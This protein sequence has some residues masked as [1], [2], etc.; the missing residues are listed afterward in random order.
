MS[1]LYYILFF[2]KVSIKMVGNRKDLIFRFFSI[3]ISLYIIIYKHDK[4]TT[5]QNRI[6]PIG[7]S[8]SKTNRQSQSHHTHIIYIY[9]FIYTQCVSCPAFLLS[10]VIYIISICHTYIHLIMFHVCDAYNSL[11][12]LYN[13]YIVCH[14]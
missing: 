4:K 11:L 2:Y 7:N 6:C 10:F 9:I 14:V 5:P 13:V 8:Y 1:L 3:V 12:K